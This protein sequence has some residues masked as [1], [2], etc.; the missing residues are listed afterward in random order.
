M[1]GRIMSSRTRS[2][3]SARDLADRLPAVGGG[4]GP[5]SPPAPAPATSQSSWARESSTTRIL[6]GRRPRRE[7]TRIPHGALPAAAPCPAR[8]TS[9]AFRWGAR[10]LLP[11]R[12]PRRADRREQEPHPRRGARAR[13]RRRR[14]RGSPSSTSTR[15]SST[16]ARA[17]RAS[18]RTTAAP[19]GLPALLGARPEHWR[20][21]DLEARSPP[22]GSPPAMARRTGPPSAASGPA[23]FFTSA[24]CT[25]R[26]PAPRRP[27]VRARRRAGGRARSPT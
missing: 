13:P 7:D 11:S 5:R 20:G 12:M 18:S 15:P 24:Y 1:S 9:G 27:G 23:R 16:T 6:E 2:G 21:W 10:A 25:P 4:D 14:P 19:A 22:S 17:R 3:A 26:R 8:T